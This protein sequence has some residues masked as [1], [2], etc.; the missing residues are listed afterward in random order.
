MSSEPHML[1]PLHGDGLLML[2]GAGKQDMHAV[3]T[4]GKRASAQ[5]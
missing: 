3:C 1:S 4:A 5:M 2:R